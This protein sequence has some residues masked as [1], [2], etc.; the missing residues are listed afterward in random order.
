MTA[1]AIAHHST[2]GGCRRSNTSRAK[3]ASASATTAGTVALAPQDVSVVKL[4]TTTIAARP[5]GI[6]SGVATAFGATSR[7]RSPHPSD[8]AARTSGNTIQGRRS[9]TC[10]AS[11]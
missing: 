3:P 10:S 4:A 6:S 2:G 7:S 8:S 9:V 1:A 5:A 11:G